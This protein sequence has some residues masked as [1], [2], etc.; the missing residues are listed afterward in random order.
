MDGLASLAAAADLIGDYEQSS[1]N[2]VLLNAIS[3]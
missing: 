1:P 3:F 2:K